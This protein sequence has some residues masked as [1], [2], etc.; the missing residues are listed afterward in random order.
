MR[1]DSGR[2]N[3]KSLYDVFAAEKNDKEPLAVVREGLC[4]DEQRILCEPE[5]GGSGEAQG[6]K[7]AGEIKSDYAA[8]V[9]MLEFCERLKEQAEGIK[10]MF[11]IGVVFLIWFIIFLFTTSQHQITHGPEDL[12]KVRVEGIRVYP[13]E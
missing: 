13:N 8:D 10:A 9:E 12:P 5:P 1:R 7:D 2:G 6:F 4:T 3:N 11:L